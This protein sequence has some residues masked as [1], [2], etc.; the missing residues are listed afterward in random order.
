MLSCWLI[1]NRVWDVEGYG[2]VLMRWQSRPCGKVACGVCY[3]GFAHY[4]G[5]RLAQQQRNQ[6]MSNLPG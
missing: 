6:T 4:I 2:G 1:P 3:P 5:F